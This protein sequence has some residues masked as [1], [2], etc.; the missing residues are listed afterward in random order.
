MVQQLQYK[1][2]SAKEAF[3][4][5]YHDFKLQLFDALA[6]LKS[7]SQQVNDDLNLLEKR[8]EA[9]LGHLVVKIQERNHHLSQDAIRDII[10]KESAQ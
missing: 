10:Y 5:S 1:E 8:L 4:F 3:G 2:K 7:A 6:S 9:I